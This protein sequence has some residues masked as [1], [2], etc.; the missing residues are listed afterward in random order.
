MGTKMHREG[1]S[2][3]KSIAHILKNIFSSNKSIHQKETETS[4]IEYF[5]YPKLGPGQF[6][7]EVAA[8]IKQKGGRILTENKAVNFAIENKKIKE[9]AIQNNSGQLKLKADYVFSTMP[10][11]ELIKGFN[12]DVPEKIKN[13]SNGLIYRDFFSVGLLLKKFNPENEIFVNGI[14]DNWIY[15]QEPDVKVGRLQVFNNWSPYMVADATKIWIGLE[16]FCRQNDEMWNM[17]DGE[18]KTFASNELVK[19]GFAQLQ[20]IEDGVV[21]RM[22]KAYPAYFGTY[23]EFDEVKKFTNQFENLFL[24]GRNGM[25]KYNNQDHSMLTAMTAV[26]NIIAGITSKDNLWEVNTEEEYHEEK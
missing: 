15:V 17:Q 26:D 2:I 21:V 24:I 9:V 3:S 16:Y 14:H 8:I 19:M 4:L 11:K 13:V 22:P 18:L 12:I 5:M 7:D 10:V 20:D 23:T 25:H 6:W 1:L